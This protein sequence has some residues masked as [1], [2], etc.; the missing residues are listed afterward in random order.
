MARFRNRE[1]SNF[2]LPFLSVM[3]GGFGAV[4]VIFLMIKPASEQETV[5]APRELLTASTR[6]DY[7]TRTEEENLL[8]LQQLVE[9]IKNQISEIEQDIEILQEET[10]IK[11]EDVDKVEDEIE[12]TEDEIDELNEE[13][14]ERKVRVVSMQQDADRLSRRAAIEIVGEGDRQYLTGMFMGGNHILIALD[15]SASMLDDSIVNILR[16]RNMDRER[17]LQSPKWQRATKTV[18]WLL[19]NIPLQSQVQVVTFNE[20]AQ[21]ITEPN[22]W[23]DASDG[24]VIRSMVTDLE[25]TLPSNGTNL[26]ALFDL[27][28]TMQPLPDNL[29]L[30]VDGLPTMDDRSPSR[31]SVSGRQRSVIFNRSVAKL[32]TGIPVNVILFPLEGDP[33]SPASYWNL[34]NMTGG[35]ILSPSSDWP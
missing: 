35:T 11:E 1:I 9:S 33:S 28:R 6:L 17:Q 23:L 13:V 20:E 4:V 14:E 2:T 8:R 30:I 7:Q 31:P 34:A 24:A 27:I 26:A 3:T 10:E 29:F 16:R 21:F 25:T 19:A 32:P 15:T 12:E 5:E 22:R 18:E